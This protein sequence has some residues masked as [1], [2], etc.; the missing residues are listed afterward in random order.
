MPYAGLIEGID[1]SLAVMDGSDEACAVFHEAVDEGSP[2]PVGGVLMTV[3]DDLVRRVVKLIAYPFFIEQIE[4]HPALGGEVHPIP[5]IDA[6]SI[7]V[8]IFRIDDC[9]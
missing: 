3:G 2:V 7:R 4:V 9:P 6:C 1:T 5:L 8:F